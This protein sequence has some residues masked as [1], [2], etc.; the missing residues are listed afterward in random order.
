MNWKN[1][2]YLLNVDRKSGRLIRGIKATRYKENTFLAYWPYWTAAIIGIVGGLIA[3]YL[4][5]LVYQQ[6]VPSGVPGALPPLGQAS[7]SFFTVL[8]TLILVASLIFTLLQQIQLAGLK[9][10]SQVMYWLPITWQEHTLASVLANLSGW[11]IALVTGL[12]AGILVYSVFN[13]I[14]LQ[15][16]LTAVIMVGAAFMASSITEILRI[17]QVRL[18]GAI[19][20]SSGKGAIWVRLI[21]TLAFF[22]IFYIVYI[23]ITSGFSSFITNLTAAQNSAWYVPFIWLALLL[24]YAV[25]GFL[26]Q[27]ILFF[28][29]SSLFIIGLYYLAVALNK[30]FGLYEPPAITVQ[31]SGE[32]MPK[33]GLLGRLGFSTVEAAIIRK[34]LRA[35]TRRRELIS[36][37]IAPIVMIIIPLFNSFGIINGGSAPSGQ[38][39][40]IFTAIIFVLPA[41]FMAMLLGEVLIGEEGQAVWR[42][43]AS[44]ISGKNLVKSKYFFTMLFSMIILLL[45]GTIGVIFYHPSIEYAAVGFFETFFVVLTLAS[46]ALAVGLK[47]PDFSVTRRARMIRQEWS[48]IGLIVCGVAGLA[49]VAPLGAIVIVSFFGGGVSTTNLA[50]AVAISAVISTV[51]SAIFYRINIGLANDLL[52]KAQI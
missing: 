28:A 8:P 15:A 32:Y 9:A 25:K 6:G 43:F 21:G 50:I 42:I 10:S 47:G 44:P 11:P 26:L 2:L 36:V 33:A 40:L 31:K 41:G 27:A 34:D 46:V 48:L 16:F 1:V 49:V 23:Y 5:V 24:S 52:K 14:I 35:F 37:Y 38:A 12:T 29:L 4:V 39:T 18:T 30:R 20:K 45:S 22:V 51:V 19:Y 13:G 17:I 7:V 3:N